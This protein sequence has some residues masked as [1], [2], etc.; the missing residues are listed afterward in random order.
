VSLEPQHYF[1]WLRRHAPL[2]TISTSPRITFN[3]VVR[4]VVLLLFWEV[5][6]LEADARLVS[7]APLLIG[8][9]PLR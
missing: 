5:N 9:L 6:L 4:S 2:R 7:L 8:L 3:E 1:R